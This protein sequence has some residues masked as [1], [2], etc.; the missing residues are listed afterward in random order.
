MHFE[1]VNKKAAETLPNQRNS[2]A[3][4]GAPFC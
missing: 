3:N 4:A 1:F 2:V